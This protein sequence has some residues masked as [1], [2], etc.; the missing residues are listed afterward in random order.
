VAAAPG[1]DVLHFSTV[2]PG[3]ALPRLVRRIESRG[4][5]VVYDLED[6]HWIPTDA[7]LTTELK[8]RARRNLAEL[9]ESP[10][11]SGPSFGVKV[12]AFG[13]EEGDHDVA[14]LASLVPRHRPHAI[15]LPKVESAATVEAFL[16]V[17][18]TA[19]VTC[20]EVVPLI[21]TTRGVDTL[22]DLLQGLA[23]VNS[24]SPVRRIM[25][26]A[27][28]YCLD[29][30]RWP[31]WRQDE[32]EFWEMV[33]RLAH[34]IEAHGFGYV[35]T[36]FAGLQASATFTSAIQRLA[37]TCRDRFTISTLDEAQVAAALRARDGVLSTPD[38]PRDAT[39]SDAEALALAHRVVTLFEERRRRDVGFVVDSRDGRF[40]PPHEYV[41]AR[42]HIERRASA[43]L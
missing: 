18:E 43:R 26:G 1:F 21:E 6:T 27:N 10:F 38:A 2:F 11:A 24:R 17:C 8:R 29:S 28:D 31:F 37:A 23:A 4:V 39:L 35:H 42:R 19:G 33:E 20:D 13:T 36:P 34:T 32:P 7:A 15:I 16:R 40:I 25:F 14:L 41:A 30:G 5:Q 12:N 22:D 9:L 3:R